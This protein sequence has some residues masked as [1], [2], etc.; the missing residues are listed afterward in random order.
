MGVTMDRGYLYLDF[1][2]IGMGISMV[3][4]TFIGNKSIYIKVIFTSSMAAL[5]SS[6]TRMKSSSSPS[7]NRQPGAELRRLKITK[8]NIYYCG[9]FSPKLI[10]LTRYFLYDEVPKL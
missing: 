3:V 8:Q 4:S 6:Y 2:K 5:K 7:L 9:K 10:P 1:V